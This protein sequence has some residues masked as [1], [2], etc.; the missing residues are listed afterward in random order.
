MATGL[1]L[2]VSGL[3]KLK[4]NPQFL[5]I[6]WQSF[7]IQVCPQKLQYR[8][9]HTCQNLKRENVKEQWQEQKSHSIHR[10]F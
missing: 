3:N 2:T 1:I 8:I 6:S 7:I 9:S 4:M 10:N 5:S